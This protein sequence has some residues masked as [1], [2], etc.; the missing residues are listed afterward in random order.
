MDV[1]S[2][3]RP[4]K[5]GCIHLLCG[6]CGRK[7]SNSPR[8][9]DDPKSAHVLRLVCD[10]HSGDKGDYAFYYDAE[11]NEIADPHEPTN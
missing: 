7:Q 6:E 2:G 8:Q 3:W 10:K 4:L 5:D 1:I 11:G 9:P